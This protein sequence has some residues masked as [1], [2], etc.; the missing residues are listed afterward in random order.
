MKQPPAPLPLFR[1]EP[2]PPAVS[3]AQELSWLAG[4]I[5]LVV[6]M[7]VLLLGHT[8]SWQHLVGTMAI[9]FLAMV[10]EAL[11]FMLIGSL[12]GGLIEVFVP[13]AWVE[14][15]FQRYQFS[16]I[17]IAGA[18]GLV[19]PICECAVVPIIRRLLT[20]GVPFGAA[21]AFLLGGP[22]VNILVAAST[23]VAYNLNWT[24]V[25]LRLGCGYG[26]AVGIGIFLSCWFDNDRALA[27][28]VRLQAAGCGHDHCG[29]STTGQGRAAKCWHALGHA[30][31]DFFG[32]GFYLIIGTFI[33]SFF[34]TVVSMELFSSLQT[35]PWLAIL[36][37]MGMAVLLNL[38]SEA[39]AFI[40]ASFQGML[41]ISA[42]LAFM[43]LGPMFDLKLLLMYFGVFRKK[44]ILVLVTTVLVSVFLVMLAVHALFP[45]W[46]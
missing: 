15:V 17:L 13:V 29:V 30:S 32:V 11:P 2:A 1:P 31:D 12:A 4:L 46:F 14:H 40:A 42:Q 26:L 20:K 16:A 27:R 19:L 22:I 8:S 38:C 18:M 36:L 33:A 35:A 37:M 28:E 7:L 9:N 5:F 44:V 24:V 34:R 43:V 21:I 41:P 23:A 10:I 25:A 6:A 39:D 3:L 45:A